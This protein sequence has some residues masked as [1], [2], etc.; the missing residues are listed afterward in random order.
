MENLDEGTEET[1]VPQ[2][3]THRPVRQLQSGATMPVLAIDER[4]EEVYLEL[5]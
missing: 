3:H 1:S 5:K 4:T 2:R